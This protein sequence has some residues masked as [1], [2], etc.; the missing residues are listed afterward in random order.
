[1]SDDLPSFEK[2]EFK[3]VM[4]LLN[5]GKFDK[6]NRIETEVSAI[7]VCI[8]SIKKYFTD[9]NTIFTFGKTT[10]IE[11]FTIKEKLLKE[12]E[13]IENRDEEL[14]SRTILITIEE[15]NLI[16]PFLVLAST[17]IKS[18][19]KIKT[20]SLGNETIIEKEKRLSL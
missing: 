15:D 18:V 5:F 7:I 6:K 4:G 14:P 8:K 19:K 3:K 16:S 12:G 17:K 10:N 20:N 9:Y 13:I 2:D 1:M 11:T